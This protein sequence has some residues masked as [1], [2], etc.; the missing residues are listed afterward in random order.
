MTAPRRHFKL[1]LTVLV[2]S[3][4]HSQVSYLSLRPLLQPLQERRNV[5]IVINGEL[6]VL[7]HNADGNIL[8]RSEPRRYLSATTSSFSAC[9]CAWRPD[10]GGEV[11]LSGERLSEGTE[12][13]LNQIVEI[14]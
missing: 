4:T 1:P 7:S 10:L 3:L 6:H 14:T 5:V 2:L 12:A 9:V 8:K 11:L 13:M